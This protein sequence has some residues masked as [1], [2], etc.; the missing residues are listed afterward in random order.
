MLLRAVHE[1]PRSEVLRELLR[2]ETGFCVNKP[3]ISEEG[4]IIMQ[5]YH[6]NALH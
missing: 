2:L 4:C 5:S 6:G 1:W 3:N